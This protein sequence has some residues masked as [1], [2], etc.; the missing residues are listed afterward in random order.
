M[1]AKL[2]RVYS[3][4][5]RYDP[6]W[7]RSH[8]APAVKR[9]R[10]SNSVDWRK[11]DIELAKAVRKAAN[12]LRNCRGRPKLISK[13]AIAREMGK[14]TLLRQKISKLP[15]TAKALNSVVE[16]RVGYALRRVQWSASFFRSEGILP[17][18]WQLILR[19][20]VYNLRNDAEIE[21]AIENA[22]KHSRGIGTTQGCAQEAYAA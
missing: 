18:R 7:L 10:R 21:A 19:A 15:L 22:I 11:R 20:N 12:R 2:P 4:L 17:S 5:R 16:T 1:R 14:A 9:K 8:T 6:V 3:F 13:S